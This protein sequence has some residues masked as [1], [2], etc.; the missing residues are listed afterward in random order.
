MLERWAFKAHYHAH[1]H[2]NIKQT[3][4]GETPSI[5]RSFIALSKFNPQALEPD[6]NEVRSLY[7]RDM[8]LL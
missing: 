6:T 4:I 8:C 7:G 3:V 5:N 2:S 1:I